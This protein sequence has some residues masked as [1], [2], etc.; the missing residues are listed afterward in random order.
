MPRTRRHFDYTQ[1]V[2]MPLHSNAKSLILK[3]LMKIHRGRQAWPKVI[4][5]LSDSQ[6]SDLN[7]ERLGR[8]MPPIKAEV[9]FV[10]NHIYQS[11]V[12]DDGYTFDDVMEQISSAM[13]ETSVF[14]ESPKMSGLVSTITREDGYG[15]QVI[16]NGVLECSARFPRAELY[17]VIPKG[18]RK[19]PPKK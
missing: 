8:H 4:G 17:S 10:G 3:N 18:D 9:V 2:N 13:A 12:K 11:R 1:A 19:K 6:L 14:S 15:N 5:S 7:K 16:D